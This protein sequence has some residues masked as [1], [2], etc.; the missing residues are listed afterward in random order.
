M[1]NTTIVK[2]NNQLTSELPKYVQT[3]CLNK[4]FRKQFIKPKRYSKM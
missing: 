3:K 2:G 1:L 4:T